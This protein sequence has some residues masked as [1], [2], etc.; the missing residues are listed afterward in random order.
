MSDFKYEKAAQDFEAELIRDMTQST[1]EKVTVTPEE[2]HSGFS[3][4]D[5]IAGQVDPLEAAYAAVEA[6]MPEPKEL[7]TEHRLNEKLASI[8]DR[9]RQAVVDFLNTAAGE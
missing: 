5:K 2:T 4:I 3:A 1:D 9:G 6:E 8:K 7:I